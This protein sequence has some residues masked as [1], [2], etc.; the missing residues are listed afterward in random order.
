MS[1]RSP[2]AVSEGRKSTV[3]GSATVAIWTLVSRITG[4]I[5]VVAIGAVLGPTFFANVFLSAN[6]IPQITFSAVVGTVLSPVIIPAIVRALRERGRQG[7][8]EL[9]GRVAGFLLAGS[10]AVAA[11]L[12]LA[13]P[14]LAWTLTIGVPQE[15]QSQARVLTMLMVLLV[16]PQVVL[17]TMAVLGAAVQQARD[18]F[19]LAAAAPAI[20]NLGQVT[21]MVAVAVLYDPGLE[22]SEVPLGLVVMLGAGA[23]GSVALHAAVQLYGAARVGITVRPR[24]GWR[25]EPATQELV[26]RLRD[27]VAVAAFPAMSVYALLTVAATLPGGVLV[28]QL[29]FQVYQASIALGARAVSTA[30][31]PGL[32]DA[33]SRDDATLFATAWRQVFYYVVLAGLPP[34][35]LLTAFAPAIAVTLANG[36]LSNHDLIVALAMCIAVLAVA[37]LPAAVHEVGRQALFARLDVRGPRLAAA[38]H[39]AV[40]VV[41]GLLTVLLAAGTLRLVGIVLA[42]LVAEAGAAT[43]ILWRLR[44]AIRPERSMDARR[45]ATAGLAALTMLPVVGA[46]WIIVGRTGGEPLVDVPL[47]LMFGAVAVA[48]FALSVRALDHRLGRSSDTKTLRFAARSGP[49]T[50]VWTSTHPGDRRL[51]PQSD[52]PKDRTTWAEEGEAGQILPL[53]MAPRRNRRA[54]LRAGPCRPAYHVAPP[55][56]SRPS[57][58][59]ERGQMHRRMHIRRIVLVV[60]AATLAVLVALGVAGVLAGNQPEPPAFTLTDADPQF[61]TLPVATELPSAEECSQRVRAA[62]LKREVRPE[63]ASAN[64]STPA[65]LTLPPWPSFWAPQVNEKYVP[66]IDGQFTGSTD[67]II[68]WGACKWG[69]DANIV[70]AMAVSE[71][72]WRQPFEGDPEDDPA[73]CVGGYTRPCPTSFG[74]LQL[75][76]TTRPGS[77]P[78]SRDHTAFNVDYSLAVLRGCYEGYV[79]Y[80]GDGYAAGDLWGCVGWHYSGEWLSPAAL[81]YIDTTQQ[82]YQQREWLS[83]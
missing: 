3:R 79:T 68:A 43:L 35:F 37:Q 78:G 69:I 70:R 27:S 54:C 29:A 82:H 26:R 63:N 16:A 75:K 31:L 28:M 36:E 73:V 77:W 50:E 47:G 7:A 12:V 46:G 44:R 65:G 17:Y 66:R 8:G 51:S 25:S 15:L 4:V 23:T 58:R 18:R 14:V 22:I 30:A 52:N 45:L 48:L 20:E 41:I 42:T 10:A 19:A 76:H 53:H 67:E 83:W 62:G 33:A 13:S 24:L 81:Q 6:T 64:N 38:T 21:T 60:V 56:W 49:G 71:T 32:S 11:V 40:T 80:L 1:T 39:F 57:F 34:L 59:L 55:A 74:L 9:I 72:F 5:R 2:A 61:P